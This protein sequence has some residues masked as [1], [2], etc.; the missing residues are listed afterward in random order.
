MVFL[1]ALALQARKLRSAVGN[2]NLWSLTS[3]QIWPF[4]KQWDIATPHIRAGMKI[5]AR[6]GNNPAR[7][8]LARGLDCCTRGHQLS[9]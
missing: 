6:G 3:R 8:P 9:A 7:G 5:G 1:S 4:V 2:Q